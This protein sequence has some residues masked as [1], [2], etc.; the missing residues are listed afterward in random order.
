MAGGAIGYSIYYNVFS[1]HFK[2]HVVAEISKVA[3]L[4]GIRSKA[5]I[6]QIVQLTAAG[7]ID[8]IRQVPGVTSDALAEKLIVAG[9]VAYAESY[10]WVYY[11]SIAFGVASI[12]ASLFLG[13]IK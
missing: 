6:V 7:L 12:I 10:P 8:K 5:A 3:I 1:S 13:D 9:Q 4:G 11:I 2:E